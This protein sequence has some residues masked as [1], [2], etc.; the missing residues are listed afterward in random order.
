ML[1]LLLILGN[2]IFRS[3]TDETPHDPAQAR[4]ELDERTPDQVMESREAV[5]EIEQALDADPEPP[6]DEPSGEPAEVTA[7]AATPEDRDPPIPEVEEAPD[8]VEATQEDPLSVPEAHSPRLPDGMFDAVVLIGADASGYLADSIILALFPEGGSPPALVSIPRDLY[9]YNFCSDDY[10]RVNANLGGCPGYANGAELLS[11]AIEEFTGV[12]V[13]HYVRVDFDGFVELVDGLGGV[14]V[15]FEHPTYDEKAALD[16]PEP[17]CRNDGATALAYARSRN[18]QQLVDGEWQRAWSSDFSRQQHQRELLLKLAGRLRSASLGTLL[19]SFQ[20]LSHTFRMDS[21]WSVAEAV[22][23]VWRYSDFEPSLVT[24]LSIP[25][26]DYRTTEGAQ[27]L[28]PTVTFNEL[29]SRWWGPA[30]R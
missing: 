11:L 27:V 30:A 6:P 5:E 7:P 19:T 25:V 29:L 17:S 16:I 21:G 14:E 26:E 13:D 24:Q 2:T 18:A 23:W 4:I 22:E 28:L 1:A 12:R 15:C 10:R 20:N 9:L 8:T 3:F